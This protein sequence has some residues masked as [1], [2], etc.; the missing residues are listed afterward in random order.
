MAPHA[1]FGAIL[2]VDVE[3]L[4]WSRNDET[5]SLDLRYFGLPADASRMGRGLLVRMLTYKVMARKA[6][7]EECGGR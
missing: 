3:I 1:N 4:F 2:Q 6:R 5:H 7:E